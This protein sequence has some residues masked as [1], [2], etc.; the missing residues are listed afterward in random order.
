MAIQAGA[1][2]TSTY[3]RV[4]RALMQVIVSATTAGLILVGVATIG[5][6]GASASPRETFVLSLGDRIQLDA[7]PIGCRATRLAGHGRRAY[8]EC[9]RTG[10]LH[11]TYGV[12]FSG[13]DVLV[14]RFVGR[15]EAR[16]V[17][18]AS[19]SGSATR[20]N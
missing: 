16:V 18:H 10:A 19:H 6:D 1:R 3:Q 7:A 15:R 8:L 4:A 20:C 5:Q 17:F 14:A 9:R 2:S 12:F 11:G 13:E